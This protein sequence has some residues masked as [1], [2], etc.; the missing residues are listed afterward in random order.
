MH[1][2][3]H[4]QP[5]I[6]IYGNNNSCCSLIDTSTITLINIPPWSRRDSDLVNGASSV[7]A[8]CHK[9]TETADDRHNA[10]CHR[11]EAV[12]VRWR[13]KEHC[14]IPPSTHQGPAR[15]LAAFFVAPDSV[16]LKVSTNLSS[17][18]W[19]LQPWALSSQLYNLLKPFRPEHQH[20]KQHCLTKCTN[21]AELKAFC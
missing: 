1:S 6:P 21:V 12:Q 14:K 10:K 9:G 16:W 17:L 4:H 13:L 7:E 20:K 5:S 3:M 18:Y 2:L 8:D 19:R 15:L 11:Q